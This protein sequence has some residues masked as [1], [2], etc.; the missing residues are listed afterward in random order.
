MPNVSDL[1]LT[2]AL[3]LV[4]VI[5]GSGIAATYI[6]SRSMR[7]KR[8]REFF[9]ADPDDEEAKKW[10]KVTIEGHRQYRREIV[11]GVQEIAERIDNNDSTERIKIS[12]ARVNCQCQ[13]A[14][15]LIR[16]EEELEALARSFGFDT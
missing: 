15:K 1:L 3:I 10:V 8:F 14:T 7:K 5:V 11:E 13:Y 12:L 9:G 16:K 2:L 4:V 6:T